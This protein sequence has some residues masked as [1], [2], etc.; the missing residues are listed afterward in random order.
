MTSK[1]INSERK[2][3]LRQI[4]HHLKPIV[5]ISSNGLSESVIK[6]IDRALNDHELIKI[7]LNVENKKEITKK[8]CEKNNAFI[9]QG[10]GNVILIIR[11]SIKPNPKL[12]NL[13]KTK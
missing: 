2:K 7:K 9:V 3:Y 4:G 11:E 12:S 10:I 6:E 1:K 5:T 13:L 8:I